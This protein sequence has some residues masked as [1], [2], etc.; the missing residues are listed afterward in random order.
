MSSITDLAPE[1]QKRISGFVRFLDAEGFSRPEVKNIGGLLTGILKKPDVRVSALSRTLN[2]KI[3]PKKTWERLSRNLK[4][5]GLGERLIC[6][7]MKKHRSEIQ[8][9]RYCVLDLSDIQ[10][11]YA[12][13]MEGLSRVRDGDKSSHEKVSIGNGFYWINAVMADV[14]GIIPVYSEIYSLD[15]EGKDCVS[16]NSKLLGIT[17]MVHEVHPEAVYVIDRGGDR[18][19]IMAPLHK[20]WKLFVIR[21]QEQ[22]SLGLHKDSEKKTNIK[23]IAQKV[24]LCHIYKSQRNGE[25]FAVGIRRVYLGDIPLWLVASKRR[26]GGFSWYLTNVT[27]TRT[28]VMDTVLEAYGLRWRIEEYHRQIKQDYGLEKLCVRS[29]QAIKNMGV[30]V[31][32]A[33]SFCARLPENIVIRL[34]AFSNQLPRKRLCDI[35]KYP[36]YKIIAAVAYILQLTEKRSYKPLNVRKREYFQFQ[37]EFKGV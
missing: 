17:D 21:G 35:P 7:N 24:N 37:L 36:Y 23:T 31:M 29:Y 1:I 34:L 18:N 5:D 11:A 10:K 22:R 4:R 26:G 16:E 6:A 28:E 15:H 32:L 14:E 9:K 19:E 20:D 27:G 25:Q 2:E 12:V 3:T 33:A 8:K 30:L 13:Q